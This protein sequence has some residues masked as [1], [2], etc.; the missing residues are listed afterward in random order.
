MWNISKEVKGKF[1]KCNLLPIHE[2]DQ[3]WEIA[4]REAIEEG[5]DLHARLKEELEEV[6]MELLN[7]LPDGFIPY[8]KNGTLNQPSLPR[9]VREEYLQWIRRADKEFEQ[10][11]DAAY[12][13][14][15]HA[16]TYLPPAVQDIFAESLHDSTIERIVRERDTLHLYVNTDGGFSSKSLIHFTFQNVLAEETDEPI[17]VGQWFIYNELQKT[18]DGFAFRVLFECP[19]AEWTI[20]MK[21]LDAEYYYRPI[22]YTILRD[23]G[24]IEETSLPEYVEQLNL[25]HR[26][27]FI[28]PHVKSAIKA[29]SETIIVENGKIE[30]R[31][32]EMVVTIGNELFTYNLDEINPI[33]F[34]YTDVYEDPYARFSE[35]VPTEE[36]ETA[37]L[38]EDLELQV[39]AWNTLYAN[40]EELADIINRVLRKMDR[41]EENEMML[42]IYV[43]HFYKK[44]ILSEAVIEKYRM[45]IDEQ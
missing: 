1:L 29:F 11:L 40:P 42:S 39:R 17:Q 44:G 37:A 5:E 10:I 23:E 35:P 20:A 32:N 24:K 38:S 21:I 4:Q 19:D 25:E 15:K 7:V 45:L 13:Q 26:Y 9:T 27:W 31:Q 12:E 2:S 8:V 22:A 14:T 34:I 43:S 16:V 30:C 6:K 41:T 18:D 36:L 28:T 3:D 33:S